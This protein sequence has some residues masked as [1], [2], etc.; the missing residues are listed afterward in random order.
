M[1]FYRQVILFLEKQ[2]HSVLMWVQISSVFLEENL[3]SEC[4]QFE[5]AFP[6]LGVYPKEILRQTRRI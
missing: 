1:K 6:F 4:S 5:L 3:T 2:A